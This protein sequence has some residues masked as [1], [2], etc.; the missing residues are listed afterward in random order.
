MFDWH[1]LGAIRYSQ[2]VSDRWSHVERLLSDLRLD[3]SCNLEIR[4]YLIRP[5]EADLLWPVYLQRSI[6]QLASIN[7]IASTPKLMFETEPGERQEKH[8]QSLDKGWSR[9]RCTACQR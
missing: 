3:L 2:L 8:L 7:F 4:D 1:T 6:E 5:R 9:L